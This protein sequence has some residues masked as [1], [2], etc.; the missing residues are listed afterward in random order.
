M[1]TINPK[2]I[3]QRNN[4]LFSTEIKLKLDNLE[5]SEEIV[6]LE[7]NRREREEVNESIKNII[8]INLAETKEKI[9]KEYLQFQHRI[10]DSIQTYSQQIKNITACEKRLIEQY[11]DTK[12][13]T[14]KIEIVSEKISKIDER[15]TTYEIRF[16]NLSKD[17]RNAVSKYDSLF[18]DNMTVP[19]KIG[20]YCKYKNIKEFLS[21]AFNKFN[22]FDLKRENDVSMMKLNQDKIDRFIKKFTCEMNSLRDEA[23][24]LTAKKVNYLEKRLGEETTKI[25]KSIET[26]PNNILFFDI[27]KKMNDLKDKYNDMKNINEELDIKISILENEIERIKNGNKNNKNKNT[28]KINNLSD[29]KL[30]PINENENENEKGDLKNKKNNSS[31][32][33]HKYFSLKINKSNFFKD[34][35]KNNITTYLKNEKSL[36][37][38]DINEF[39]EIFDNNEDSST[40]RNKMIIKSINFAKHRLKNKNSEN[41]M[42]N[43][44]GCKNYDLEKLSKKT[45]GAANS[46]KSFVSINSRYLEDSSEETEKKEKLEKIIIENEKE[47]INN[48][49]KFFKSR[50]SSIGEQV[51]LFMSDSREQSKKNIN[52]NNNI[53][54]NNLKTENNDKINNVKN[55][56]NF[57]I[58]NNKEKIDNVLTINPLMKSVNI[59]NRG[60]NKNILNSIKKNK[61]LENY[62]YKTKVKA[63]I[64]HNNNKKKLLYIKN[65]SDTKNKNIKKIHSLKSITLNTLNNNV[66]LIKKT[67]NNN[68][69]NN[70]NIKHNIKH[71]INHANNNV[72]NNKRNKSSQGVSNIEI[73]NNNSIKNCMNIIPTPNSEKIIPKTKP[74]QC[75]KI[76]NNYSTTISI[77]NITDISFL[78]NIQFSNQE[79]ISKNKDLPI[80]EAYYKLFQIETFKKQG[81]P[82]N[83]NIIFNS[84]EIPIIT[85]SSKSHSIPKRNIKKKSRLLYFKNKFDINRKNQENNKN[86]QLKVVPSNFKQS[87]R[88]QVNIN[89]D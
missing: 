13:K 55:F 63:K 69:N 49:N 29:V 4:S 67:N 87:K 75:P 30:I 44:D 52:I 53:P 35:K 66:H 11:A 39:E 1:T 57:K 32:N 82:K 41:S 86:I 31:K 89:D 12:I 16:N 20:N 71:N 72:N 37:L 7:R 23:I 51:E 73:F 59:L 33:I 2:K 70:N 85:N 88:I 43:S 65:N 24:Q 18:L 15:L 25:N 81:L 61:S 10:N 19:G 83:N 42:N 38:A 6:T 28:T 21:Y 62:K 46:F 5:Q 22:E 40:P 27:E 45:I 36:N 9:H 3:I 54:I 76:N 74:V 14:D 17:F 34:N 48:K 79:I 80:K 50:S 68:N 47:E 58:E 78:N 8:A 56:Q 84:N 77:G 26:T 64:H 60:S